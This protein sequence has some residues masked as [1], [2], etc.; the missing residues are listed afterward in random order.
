[1]NARAAL[2][3]LLLALL[4]ACHPAESA[5]A[6]APEAE[7]G[8]GSVRLL[9]ATLELSAEDREAMGIELAR[10]EALTHE[11]ELGAFGRVLSDPAA[12]SVLRAPFAGEL[13]P[14]DV[15]PALGL[16]LE[17]GALV[18]RLIPRWTPQERAD[19]A[20]R[21][22]AARAELAAARNELPAL[23][24]A[25]ARAR[26]LNAQD[27]AVSDRELE[28]AEARLHAAEVRGQGAQEVLRTLEEAARGLQGEPLALRVSGAGEVV[29]L[30]A[31]AGDVLEA[32][33][34]LLRVED[35]SAPLVELDVPDGI[36][37]PR[38]I[39]TV[40]LESSREAGEFLEA[41]SLGLA[42]TAG[43]AGLFPAL[44]LRVQDA[45][46]AGLR[47]GRRVA[48]RVPSGEPARSGFLLPRAAVVR[49]AGQAFVYVQ[50]EGQ[51]LERVAVPLDEPVPGGWFVGRAWSGGDAPEL[52]VRGAQNVLSF[53]LLGHQG[54]DEE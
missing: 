22:A 54:Q 38:A 1:M 11:R 24:Q 4:G 14:G 21:Q 43:T 35:P 6:A 44:L 46:G 50:R 45:G 8:S 30:G 9:G 18:F 36:R 51:E 23:E 26:A 32:G 28:E 2:A 20:A 37:D 27:K 10:P 5:A 48:A 53:E 16:P 15:Q 31:R 41:R 49:L 25:F 42:P 34:L 17:A 39:R 29:E 3:L 12:V 19:L 47:P 52:V 7:D 33:A 40:R 13:L